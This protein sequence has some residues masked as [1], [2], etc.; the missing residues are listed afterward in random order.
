MSGRWQK[1]A[2]AEWVRNLSFN[3]LNSQR[4]HLVLLLVNLTNKCTKVNVLE[5][6]TIWNLCD[7]DSFHNTVAHVIAE[8]TTRGS[9]RQT[10]NWNFF[11][12]RYI[13]SR[14]NI[15]NVIFKLHRGNLSLILTLFF[16]V[17]SWKKI[18]S[19]DVTIEPDDGEN[20]TFDCEGQKQ[21]NNITQSDKYVRT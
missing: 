21:R 3:P 17:L 6:W 4:P 20:K 1:R 18:F 12:L 8:N 9:A 11:I 14:K 10:S 7:R 2:R 16:V 5:K 19:H 15:V 13:A